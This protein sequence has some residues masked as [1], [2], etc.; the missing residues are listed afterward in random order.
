MPPEVPA[1]QP[2]EPVWAWVVFGAFV[3]AMLVLDLKV[4]HKKPHEVRTREALGWS[5]FWVALALVFNAGLWWWKGGTAATEFFVAYLLEKSLSID[6]LFVFIVLFQYFAIPPLLQHRVLFLGILGAIVM[7]LFFIVALAE[8][9]DEW[10]WMMWVFGAFLVLT[11]AKLMFAGDGPK[12]PEKNIALRFTRKLMPTTHEFDGTALTVVKDGVR[13]ATPLLL[14]LVVIEATDVVFA[15]DSVPAC[16]AVTRDRFIVFTSNIFAILG[17]R[18]LYFLLARFL[19]S[20]RF[21]KYGL[22]VVLAFVGVKMILGYYAEPGTHAVPT[23]VSLA[24]IAGVL[25]LATA[26]SFLFP[27]KPRADA[28]GAAGAPE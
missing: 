17:L 8:A 15:I 2:D 7:R 9:L 28:P 6:N 4:F 5:I 13:H 11:G 14:A 10:K 3:V 22:A 26:A 16:L 27:E 25:G 23:T 18:A 1:L 24:V 19:G 12:D 21:L 20:F